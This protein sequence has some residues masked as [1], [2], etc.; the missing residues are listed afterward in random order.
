[1]KA[2]TKSDEDAAHRGATS[3]KPEENLVSR[4]EAADTKKPEAERKAMPA[5]KPPAA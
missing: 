1:M 2:A 4:E 5:E 3:K